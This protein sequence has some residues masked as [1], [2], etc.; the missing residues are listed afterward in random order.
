M[1]ER[2]R[3]LHFLLAFVVALV[4]TAVA[5]AGTSCQSLSSPGQFVRC[6]ADAEADATLEQIILAALDG[7]NY[8]EV[9]AG[10]IRVAPDAVK[11]LLQRTAAKVGA[12][13]TPANERSKRAREVLE[14]AAG[15]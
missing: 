7:P 10:M 12:P 6:M 15:S 14:H 8:A 5:I 4:V 9:L 3:P 1:R 13:G 11:C 2:A